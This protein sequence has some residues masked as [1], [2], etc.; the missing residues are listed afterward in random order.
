MWG[1]AVGKRMHVNRVGGVSPG[2]HL[3]SDLLGVGRGENAN[4]VDILKVFGQ[5]VEEVSH[6]VRESNGSEYT[7]AK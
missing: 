1:S 2:L 7:R 6:S 4:G 3:L 5:R